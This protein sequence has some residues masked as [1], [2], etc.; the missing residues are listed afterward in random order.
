[1]HAVQVRPQFVHDLAGEE[2]GRGGGE[3]HHLVLHPD[4]GGA[5]YVVKRPGIAADIVGGVSADQV[6]VVGAAVVDDVTGGGDL[7][8]GGVV[9]RLIAMQDVGAKPNFDV[10]AHLVDVL[11]L[12][13]LVGAN[14][15][16]VAVQDDVRGRTRIAGILFGRALHLLLHDFFHHLHAF[17]LFS[18]RGRLRL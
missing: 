9:G 12:F 8:G 6:L 18:G 1:M 10:A 17:V 14:Q 4:T 3:E 13:L 2:E 7:P 11:V 15:H 16:F 5:G